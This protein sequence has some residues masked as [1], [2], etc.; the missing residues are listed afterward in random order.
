MAKSMHPWAANQIVRSANA[1]CLLL[2]ARKAPTHVLHTIATAP[3]LL[4]GIARDTQRAMY[5]EL[6]ARGYCAQLAEIAA[7]KQTP[8]TARSIIADVVLAGLVTESA[9]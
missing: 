3:A 7:R 4:R 2:Q 9:A 5:K 6:A 1:E 8:S